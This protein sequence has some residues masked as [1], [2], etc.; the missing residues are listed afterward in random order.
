MA[1]LAERLDASAV[2]VDVRQPDEYLS[3]HVPGAVLIPLNDVPDR[4]GELPTDREVLV[5]CRSGGRSYVASEFLAANGVQAV[6]VAGGTRP[7]SRAVERSS[8]ARAPRDGRPPLGRRRRRPRRGPGRCI[9]RADLCPRHRVPPRAHLLPPAGPAAAVVGRP[10]R[11]GRPAGGR[12]RPRWPPLLDGPGLAVLHAAQQDLEVLS[13]GLRHGARPGC[14]TPSWRPASSATPRRRSPTWWRPSW[15]CRSPRPTGCPTG[16]AGPSAATSCSYAAADVLHLLDLQRACRAE[17]DELGRLEWALDECEELRT[18]PTGPGRARGRLAPAQGPA[19]PAGPGPRRRP[20]GGGVARAAGG[21]QRPA[22]R[23][24][25]S[26]DLAVLG[27]AQRPPSTL[28]QLRASPGGRGAPRPRLRSATSCSPPWPRAGRRPAQLRTDDGGPDLE[29]QLRPAVTLV[30]A[31]VSQLARDQRL[32]TALLA[33]RS[34]LGDL[35]GGVPTARLASGWRAEVL[36]DDVAA[37]WPGR[38]RWRSSRRG[39]LR[40]LRLS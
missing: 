35:L 15:G 38:P 2:V 7:G 19:H 23:G 39:Q 20:G 30:S 31:W 26:P 33:T 18:R 17:L 21:R 32:D 8:R 10:D 25:S 14:S 9:G 16:C 13:Q 27:I 5:V 29:R 36:G 24:S 6:N 1:E 40:L 37:S 4:Y 11:A 3:G 28:D 22:G 34:D 12:R